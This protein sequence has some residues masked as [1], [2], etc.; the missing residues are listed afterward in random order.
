MLRSAPLWFWVASWVRQ[1]LSLLFIVLIKLFK[2]IN[3]RL[4]GHIVRVVCWLNVG[5]IWRTFLDKILFPSYHLSLRVIVSWDLWAHLIS[6]IELSYFWRL[7]LFFWKL[8]SYLWKMRWL[9]RNLVIWSWSLL[10]D[11]TGSVDIFGRKKSSCIIFG[12]EKRTVM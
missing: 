10:D 5:K 8:N 2:L 11:S 3:V 9:L 1:F 7:F 4:I 12:Q 6:K